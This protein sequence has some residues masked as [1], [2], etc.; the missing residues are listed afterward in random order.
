MSNSRTK[1]KHFLEK[2]EY[3]HCIHCKIN[4]LFTSE[5]FCTKTK[6]KF[7]LAYYCKDCDSTRK[8]VRHTNNKLADRTARARWSQNNKS[9]GL[10]TRCSYSRMSTSNLFCEKHFLQNICHKML[11]TKKRWQELETLLISQNSKCYYTG[12][13]LILGDNASIDHTQPQ[14]KYPEL[15]HELSNLHWVDIRVNRMKREMSEEEFFN[16]CKLVV[17]KQQVLAGE[18]QLAE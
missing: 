1:T 11:G 5:F 4:K 7:G 10:C 17:N 14:I 18:A 6:G 3:F 15:K 12:L 16:L 9:K 13:D 8:S 2:P